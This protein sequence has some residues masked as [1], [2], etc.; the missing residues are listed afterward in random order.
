MKRDLVEEEA[1]QLENERMKYKRRKRFGECIEIPKINRNIDDKNIY[2][3]VKDEPILETNSNEEI[4]LTKR[5]SEILEIE[6][7][8]QKISIENIKREEET[9]KKEIFQKESL[10]ERIQREGREY[11]K[12][13]EESCIEEQKRNQE[14]FERYPYR[15][16]QFNV[17][18]QM[19]EGEILER[20]GNVYGFKEPNIPI[21]LYSP[22]EFGRPKDEMNN[23]MSIFQYLIIEYLITK[24]YYETG[25]GYNRP[26]ILNEFKKPQ[27][28]IKLYKQHI[29]NEPFGFLLY[30]TDNYSIFRRDRYYFEKLLHN[31]D[32]KFFGG[33]Y[34]F[35]SK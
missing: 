34:G 20:V 31:N 9:P 1:N 16:D 30:I 22:E 5:D 26:Y 10:L 27:I 2:I 19:N 15:S 6:N 7:L 8:L 29:I 25:Q 3:K 28:F 35:C 4:H 21:N 33:L 18:R 11:R 32:F 13:L 24:Y 14:D 17:K 23:Y 12:R